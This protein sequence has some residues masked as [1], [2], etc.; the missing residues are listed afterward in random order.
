M[1]FSR[2]FDTGSN[3]TIA[4]QAVGWDSGSASTAHFVDSSTTSDT[5]TPAVLP[6][7]SNMLFASYTMSGFSL[8]QSLWQHQGPPLTFTRQSVGPATIFSSF[9]VNL[10]NSV[11][12]TRSCSNAGS[13]IDSPIGGVLSDSEFFMLHGYRNTF[14]QLVSGS[15][16]LGDLSFRLDRKNDTSYRIDRARSVATARLCFSTYDLEP[17]IVATTTSTSGTTIS[18][19]TSTS[20]SGTAISTSSTT[21]ST[22]ISSTVPSTTAAAT[23]TPA[24]TEVGPGETTTI[25]IFPGNLTLANQS[26]LVVDIGITP[27]VVAGTL[28]IVEGSNLVVRN[29]ATTGE[30]IVVQASGGICG[31]FDSVVATPQEECSMATVA[32]AAYQGQTLTV[33]VDVSDSG[34]CSNSAGLSAGAIA[35][36][37][38][39]GVV[40]ILAILA[41]I[42][43][44]YLHKRKTRQ[45]IETMHVNEQCKINQCEIVPI[46]SCVATLA[47]CR[48]AEEPLTLAVTL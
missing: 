36:I 17:F 15:A 6:T 4:W 29:V 10:N 20:T 39:G 19:I 27:T 3:V 35:G 48:A 37:A 44:A 23:T 43:G 22:A 1:R 26:T 24:P 9:Y 25:Q 41:A 8:G 31:K 7:G 11:V 38:I 30:F 45:S 33:S 42:I 47:T 21:T 18:T 5:Y 46:C 12:T 13:S 16:E 34:A 40:V 32:G 28:T 14:T 2:A